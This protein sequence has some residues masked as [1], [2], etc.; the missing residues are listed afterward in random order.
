METGVLNCA[1]SLLT[2]RGTMLIESEHL[3]ETRQ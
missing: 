3:E 1:G 2:P